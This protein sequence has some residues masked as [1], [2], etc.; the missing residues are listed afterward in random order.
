[1]RYDIRPVYTYDDDTE[2][3][4]VKGTEWIVVD[5]ANRYAPTGYVY[6]TREDALNRARAMGV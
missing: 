6:A 4:Q 5:T 1:M 2:D 3:A